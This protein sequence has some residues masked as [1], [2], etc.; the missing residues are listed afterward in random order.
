LYTN[1]HIVDLVA[2][3]LAIITGVY[4]IYRTI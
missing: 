1:S 2:W 3:V 4:F